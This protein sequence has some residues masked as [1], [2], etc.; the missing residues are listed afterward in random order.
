M[1]TGKSLQGIRHTQFVT[2][3][4]RTSFIL[5][6]VEV[7]DPTIRFRPDAVHHPF[8]KMDGIRAVNADDNPESEM[9]ARR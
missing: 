4:H 2:Q 9:I 7:L 3:Q 6:R 5:K 1:R 8:I